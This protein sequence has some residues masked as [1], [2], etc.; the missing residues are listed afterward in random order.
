MRTVYGLQLYLGSVY[1][2]TRRKN[3]DWQKALKYAE[4][5]LQAIKDD[6]VNVEG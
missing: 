5:I 1:A 3:I 4:Q 2:S 6:E